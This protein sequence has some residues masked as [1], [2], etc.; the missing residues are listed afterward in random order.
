MPVKYS[1]DTPHQLIVL[2]AAAGTYHLPSQLPL[3]ELLT[4]SLQGT[5]SAGLGNSTPGPEVPRQVVS[6]SRVSPPIW[7]IEPKTRL[8]VSF[9]AI[10]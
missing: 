5:L 8:R 1:S 2:A 4:L 7:K 3:S 10:F 6:I 9:R